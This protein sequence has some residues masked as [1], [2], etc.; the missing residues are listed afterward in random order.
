MGDYFCQINGNIESVP[1]W[2]V[3]KPPCDDCGQR[4]VAKGNPARPL[5]PQKINRFKMDN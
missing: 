5:K 4:A 3:S 1:R 2:E